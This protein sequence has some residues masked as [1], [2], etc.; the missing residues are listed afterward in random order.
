ML[1]THRHKE[2]RAALRGA[3]LTIGIGLAAVS[4]I[5]MIIGP[6]QAPLSLTSAVW[7][8]VF[9]LTSLASGRGVSHGLCSRAFVG[10][11]AA[12]A[13][14]FTIA[15]G[16]FGA[17]VAWPS[18]ALAPIATAYFFDV[19]TGVRL[20][21]IVS[22]V[23][24]FLAGLEAA[25]LADAEPAAILEIIAAALLLIVVVI[26][27][28]MSL[29]QFEVDSES[30]ARARQNSEDA[31]RLLFDSVPMRLVVKDSNDCIVKINRFAAN[32]F[33][34]D[35]DKVEG[36]IASLALPEWAGRHGTG[37]R[38]IIASAAPRLG[39]VERAELKN[40]DAA[41]I[42][43]DKI[44]L[45]SAEG[46]GLLLVASTDV[47]QQ[48]R[49]RAQIEESAILASLATD[50]ARD[51]VW[52][53]DVVDRSLNLSARNFDLLDEDA[54]DDELVFDWWRSRVH[55][56]DLPLVMQALKLHLES[57]EPYDVRYRIRRGDGGFSWWRSRGKAVRD[58]DG[59]PLRMIGT[60][61]DVIHLMEEGRGA[62]GAGAP[63]SPANLNL[64]EEIRTPLDNALRSFR[65]L[66]S[67]ALTQAQSRHVKLLD[68]ALR[69]LDASLSDAFGGP[70]EDRE[71][72]SK[73]EYPTFSVRDVLSRLSDQHGARAAAK[74][75]TLQTACAP[76]CANAYR[77]DRDMLES[78]LD[79]L[80]ADALGIA[81]GRALEVSVEPGVGARGANLVF[82]VGLDRRGAPADSGKTAIEAGD[83]L[84]DRERSASIARAREIAH[85]IGGRITL[86]DGA[87]A[88]VVAT[89]E[90]PGTAIPD[91][92]SFDAANE[93]SAI[94]KS[95]ASVAGLRILAAEDSDLNQFVLRSML[96]YHKHDLFF[97]KNGRQALEVWERG[98]F[99]LVLMD[100]QMPVM[101]G[102]AAI[103]EIRSAERQQG[104]GRIPII[105]LTANAMNHQVEDYVSAGADAHVAKPI[106]EGDLLDAIAECRRGRAEEGDQRRA[107]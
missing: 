21:V 100:I 16:G 26:A 101:D 43:M 35:A 87:V 83:R 34:V 40:G 53:W 67:T 66:R 47:T 60:N 50:G 106:I 31:S 2:R 103:R 97:V 28:L 71:T 82:A 70:S 15:T 39:H 14:Y 90:A 72:S 92:G 10:A 56:E 98:G 104:R 76:D 93:A 102:V 65:D 62:Q 88:G 84:R 12:G 37:D 42:R 58:S 64:T 29:R 22:I 80:I 24:V 55:P 11:L 45:P 99:D 36:Q 91:E 96:E 7:G 74:G 69:S 95:V 51:G 3:A 46:G 63:K 27:M 25:T 19:K 86:S 18:L 9:L 17:A 41:W 79:L 20:G 81:E 48:F 107:G 8:L 4:S 94:D 32:A 89:F 1:H 23:A 78:V 77:G 30:A 49:A 33:G 52:T 54:P 13:F 38:E 68:D 105:A 6:S 5:G 61:S 73:D 85:S 59:R 44:P 57:D 75:V